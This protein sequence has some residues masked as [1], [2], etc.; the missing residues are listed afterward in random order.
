M[1]DCGGGDAGGGSVAS[2]ACVSFSSSAVATAETVSGTVN[3]APGSRHQHQQPC[4]E[5]LLPTQSGLLRRQHQSSSGR[6]SNSSGSTKR[7]LANARHKAAA[8]D[9]TDA[10]D[11]RND[12][13]KTALMTNSEILYHIWKIQVN[14]N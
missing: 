2:S 9:N 10:V 7:S 12:V 11:N 4:V 3:K 14:Y 6:S 5:T 13:P 1:H 8:G